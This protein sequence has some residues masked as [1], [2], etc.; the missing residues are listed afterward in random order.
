MSI[1]YRRAIFPSTWNNGHCKYRKMKI[2]SHLIMI[3]TI[4]RLILL[5]FFLL[6]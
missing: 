5:M 2:A 4:D 1:K 6:F 3:W